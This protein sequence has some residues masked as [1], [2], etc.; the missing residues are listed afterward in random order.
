[1]VELFDGI[2]GVVSGVVD[3][4][5]PFGGTLATALLLVAK[6]KALRN[7]AVLVARVN[8]SIVSIRRK[9]GS[10]RIAVKVVGLHRSLLL[11]SFYRKVR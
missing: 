7:F 4:P 1:M 2:V 9:N 6:R 3:D 8:Y 10:R 11:T 5:Y